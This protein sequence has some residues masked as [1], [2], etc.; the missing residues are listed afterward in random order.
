[1][2]P[3]LEVHLLDFAGDL[4]G[5]RLTVEFHHKLREEQRFA[6]L[7]ALK[8]AIDADIAAARA[9]ARSTANEEP[10]MTDYKAT[11]NL[12]DTAFPMKAGL[13]QREPQILQR[14]DS[15]GLY[16]SCAKLARIVR[17]SSCTT[18][19]LC[20]RH[21]PHRSCA[22]QDSQGHDRPLENPVRLRR[23]VRAGLGL[24]R[25]ADRAQGRSD[26]RQEP[27]RRP[28]REL[29]R[30][31]ATEQI[32]GQK[33]E[34]IRLGVLGDWDNPTRPWTS[35]TRPVKSAPWPKWSSAASCS[36]ASSR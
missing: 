11:L 13:P 32:E 16:G 10:E 22:E 30:A 25:P 27:G 24:P 18:A 1:M 28:T 6:S 35:P 4:Y 23:A 33:T 19:L 34:F 12:P 20:Q 9:L 31:Y 2:A 8:S 5:R 3:H 29:C 17:S 36:R 7:E 26:P 14:W 21:D 15:I